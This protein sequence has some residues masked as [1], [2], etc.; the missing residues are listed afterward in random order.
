MASRFLSRKLIDLFLE[1]PNAGTADPCHAVGRATNPACNDV[2][3]IS[4]CVHGDRIV[5]ARF[6]TQGCVSAVA[7]TAAAALLAEGKTVA[8][9]RDLTVAEIV[10]FLD[11]V[12]DAKLACVA[13]GPLALA[14][15]LDSLAGRR[16]P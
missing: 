3:E 6:R 15:A 16:Q 10:A 13:T 9:A 12:P 8:E 11:G 5:Q 4:L 1:P 7:G 2:A 14:Q